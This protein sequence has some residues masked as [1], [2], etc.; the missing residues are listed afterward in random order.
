LSKEPFYRL[1][2]L[3]LLS[4]R[5]SYGANGNIS[6]QTS[7]QTTISY[8]TTSNY[9]AIPERAAAINNPPNKELRWERVNT[10]NAALVFGSAGNR[11]SGELSWYRKYAKD[12]LG[13]A[14]IDPTL[15]V[16]TGGNLT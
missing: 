16:L 7:A 3:P 13:E 8:Q 4:A 9:N 14:P 6:R 11:L 15:G 10:W 2:W 12:L 5:F 1:A